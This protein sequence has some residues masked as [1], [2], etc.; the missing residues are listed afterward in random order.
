MVKDGDAEHLEE[1]V[2]KISNNFEKT[3]LVLALASALAAATSEDDKDKVMA[4]ISSV[5]ADGFA[6]RVEEPTKRASPCALRLA[7]CA[8]PFFSPQLDILFDV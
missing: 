7:P 6:F 5:S 2:G 3:D 4:L 8:L 1:M